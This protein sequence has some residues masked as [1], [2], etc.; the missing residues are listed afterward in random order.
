VTF[1]LKSP[2]TNLKDFISRDGN[3]KAVLI[4]KPQ[5]PPPFKT[6]MGG[7]SGF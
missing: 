7:E 2:I 4:Y 6:R 1:E 5:N 3:K